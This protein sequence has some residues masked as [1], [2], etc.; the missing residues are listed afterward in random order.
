M[1]TYQ[2]SIAIPDGRNCTTQTL[3]AAMIGCFVE[4]MYPTYEAANK[5]LAGQAGRLR[6]ITVP[7]GRTVT[8]FGDTMKH[9]YPIQ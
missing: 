3:Y 4:D 5:A 2:C 7:S 6:I 8:V 1:I 9:G